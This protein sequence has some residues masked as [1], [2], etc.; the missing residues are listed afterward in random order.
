MHCAATAYSTASAGGGISIPCPARGVKSPEG[1]ADQ[2]ERGSTRI[3][4]DS[5]KE[6]VYALI[7]FVIGL[8]WKPEPQGLDTKPLRFFY[9]VRSRHDGILPLGSARGF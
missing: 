9:V 1:G 2:E 7:A 3:P 8:L 5:K 6:K 4:L